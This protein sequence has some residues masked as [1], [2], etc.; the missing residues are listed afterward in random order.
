MNSSRSGGLVGDFEYSLFAFGVT[1][2]FELLPENEVPAHV[3][4]SIHDLLSAVGV[5]SSL[6][7]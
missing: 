7:A 6:D 1:Y 4:P 5:S 3:M 2:L